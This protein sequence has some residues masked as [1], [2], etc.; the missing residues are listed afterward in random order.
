MFQLHNFSPFSRI[1]F[2]IFYFF[3]FF[4]NTIQYTKT[5]FWVRVHTLPKTPVPF[6]LCILLHPIHPLN[7]S[8]S[9]TMQY[10]KTLW[11]SCITVFPQPRGMKKKQ[12]D[13]ENQLIRTEQGLLM[14]R[15]IYVTARIFERQIS[16]PAPGT[17]LFLLLFCQFD[18]IL[19]FWGLTWKYK[20]EDWSRSPLFQW[21][22]LLFLGAWSWLLKLES[23]SFF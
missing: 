11:R 1:L 4:L 9:T 16:S 3:N 2:F 12:A 18:C 7:S 21:L 20:V 10:P 22:L 15:S 13:W 17:S 6:S 5:R 19:L 8:T 23:E 14:F